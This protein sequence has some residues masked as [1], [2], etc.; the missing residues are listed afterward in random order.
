MAVT[1]A[2]DF[3]LDPGSGGLG[4]IATSFDLMTSELNGLANGSAAVSSV[5]GS[6]GAFTNANT[7]NAIWMPAWLL[8]G[9]SIT[10]TGGTI[11]GWF[12]ESEDGSEF[13]A[14]VATAS[15]T[16]MAMPGTPDI[17]IPASAATYSGASGSRII[18]AN[19]LVKFP[20]ETTWKIVIQNL[21][22]ITLPSSGNILA[23]GPAATGST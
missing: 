20:F 22:G 21:L 12:L 16:V 3:L 14:Q 10:P 6:S 2:H 11:V 15:T 23:C 19:G 18:R 8:F 17:I 5:G 4:F 9:G 13:E 1:L 7:G